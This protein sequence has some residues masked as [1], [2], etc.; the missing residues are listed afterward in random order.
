[1]FS[2]VWTY[3]QVEETEKTGDLSPVYTAIV[4]LRQGYR[5]YRNMEKFPE[6]TFLQSGLKK[7]YPATVA[8]K[9]RK[10]I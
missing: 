3:F 9:I 10:F 6:K 5:I 1:M 2:F 8:N 4:L 7:N